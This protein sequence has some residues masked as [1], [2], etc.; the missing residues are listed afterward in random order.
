MNMSRL[1][2]SNIHENLCAVSDKTPPDDKIAQSFSRSFPCRTPVPLD[3]ALIK[4]TV[5]SKS[6]SGSYTFAGDTGVWV[7]ADTLH[8]VSQNPSA[9]HSD[10]SSYQYCESWQLAYTNSSCQNTNVAFQGHKTESR[11]SSPTVSS[12]TTDQHPKDTKSTCAL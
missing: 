1:P 2:K 12:A 10:S 6:R 3:K 5:Y 11:M 7:A 8:W 9:A 4:G